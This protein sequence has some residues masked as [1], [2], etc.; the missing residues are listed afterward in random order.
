[1]PS[2]IQFKGKGHAPDEFIIDPALSNFLLLDQI[3]RRT[4]KSLE[5]DTEIIRLL[6]T[7][8]HALNGILKEM[9][10]GADEGLFMESHGT[11]GTTNFVVVNVEVI[12]DHRVKG[13]YLKNDGPNDILLSHNLTPDGA[14]VEVATLD[15]T[16]INLTIVKNREIESFVYNRNKIKNIYLLAVGGNSSYRLKLVW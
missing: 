2:E 16:G 3:S 9:L 11:V 10:D 7:N 1:M 8:Q 6:Q 5:A 15:R 13:Y 4:G 12:L 14:T